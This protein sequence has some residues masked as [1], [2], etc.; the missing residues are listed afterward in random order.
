[1]ADMAIVVPT[2]KLSLSL[3]VTSSAECKARTAARSLASCAPFSS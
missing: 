1:M 3:N 2:T